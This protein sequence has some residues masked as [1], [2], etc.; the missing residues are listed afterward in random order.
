MFNDAEMAIFNIFEGKKKETMTLLTRQ[1]LE[2]DLTEEDR[3]FD[4][5]VRMA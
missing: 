2:Q 5:C 1:D 4:I 3:I